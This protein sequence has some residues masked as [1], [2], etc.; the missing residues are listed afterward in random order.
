MRRRMGN[1]GTKPGAAVKY[2]PRDRMRA[3]IWGAIKYILL[4]NFTKII[5]NSLSKT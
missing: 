2:R 3:D 4:K 5:K 1:H